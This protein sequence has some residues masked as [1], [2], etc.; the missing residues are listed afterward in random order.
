MLP[1]ALTRGGNFSGKLS[2]LVFPERVFTI[3]RTIPR[4]INAGIFN[5]IE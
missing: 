4:V 2:R 3:F 5:P 1:I